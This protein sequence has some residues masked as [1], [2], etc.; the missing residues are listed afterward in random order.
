MTNPH[1]SYL[2]CAVQRS[3]SSLLMEALRSTGLGGNPEE[4]FLGPE[5]YTPSWENSAWAKAN[6]IRSR[7]EYLDLVQRSGTSPNGV[8]GCKIMWNYFYE[9]RQ[10]LA[11]LPEYETLPTHTAL[12]ALFPNLHYLWILRRDKV[13]QAVSWA[14]AAQT[15]IY[16]VTQGESPVEARPPQ[17]DPV[18]IGNLHRLVIEGEKGWRAYFDEIGVQPYVVFYEDLV[19]AYEETARD[20]LAWMGIPV[21]NDLRFA[22]RRLQKQSDR[23]NEEWVKKYLEMTA[24]TE[25]RD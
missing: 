5:E 3:G 1:T 19:Q 6:G 13:G 22:G 15:G 21:P 14:R 7:R 11:G 8:F 20:I 17:F 9:I 24:A 23:L 4:Y 10:K 18:F 16:A 2:I 25:N 12:Q